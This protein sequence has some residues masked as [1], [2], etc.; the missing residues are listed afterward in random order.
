[1]T[2]LSARLKPS[3]LIGSDSEGTTY[4]NDETDSDTAPFTLPHP[5][6]C[7]GKKTLTIVICDDSGSVAG[8]GGTDPVSQR[9]QEARIAFRHLAGHCGCRREFGAVLH[10]DYSTS[11]DVAP[12]GLDRR[13][14]SQIENGLQEPEGA[15]G[16]SALGPSLARAKAMT[17]AFNDDHVQLVVFSDFMLTDDDPASVYAELAKF[18]GTVH[19]IVLTVEPPRELLDE[20][21]ITVTGV[22]GTGLPGEVARALF[23]SMTTRRIGSITS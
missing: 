7:S 4:R 18:P 3:R 23:A 13:G 16:S 21:G 19:A 22:S 14:L 6:S 2:L 8:L 17:A 9:Y 1:M 12:A 11:W 15:G 20:P 10:F 5:G